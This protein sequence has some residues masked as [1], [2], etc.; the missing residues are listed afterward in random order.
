MKTLKNK[1]LAG[2][3][4]TAVLFFVSVAGASAATLSTEITF[5]DGVVSPNANGSVVWDGYLV[6]PTNITSGQCESGDCTLES[7]NGPLPVI[8][9]Q[10]DSVL[11]DFK[12]FWFSMQGK[13]GT[14][15]AQNSFYVEGFDEN[16]ISVK[17]ITFTL[18]D[19]IGVFTDYTIVQKT[20][21]GGTGTGDSACENDKI[22]KSV[23]YAVT[24]GSAFENLSRVEFLATET[25]N[26][27]LDSML[28]EREGDPG[29][30]V[31]PLPAGLPLL[32][33]AVGIG[34]LIGRRK[35]KSA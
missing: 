10:S 17:K 19:A 33:T 15:D 23:G 28:F 24:L 30:G 2:A 7:G 34:G 11:F 13:G 3:A 21:E 25:A 29:G 12:S 20:G 1:L 18:S 31:I 14:T 5:E 22:C 6:E 9:R 32:L 26:T 27:R 4:S 8:T 16:N 35:R